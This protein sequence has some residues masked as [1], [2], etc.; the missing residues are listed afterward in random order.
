MRKTRPTC[1]FQTGVLASLR[2]RRKSERG[3]MTF[4]NSPF[5][6]VPRR[7]AFDRF[8]SLSIGIIR[9]LPRKD[10]PSLNAKQLIFK[11]QTSDVPVHLPPPQSAKIGKNSGKKTGKSGTAG[12]SGT[13]GVSPGLGING[14]KGTGV[15]AGTLF[16][17][18][19]GHAGGVDG[20]FFSLSAALLNFSRS[21]L[22]TGGG[23]L[24]LNGSGLPSGPYRPTFWPAGL[25]RSTWGPPWLSISG[26]YVS[27]ELP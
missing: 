8:I 12:N 16:W 19:A 18:G 9:N 17:F 5:L 21:L 3:G 23:V 27:L 1:D 13:T 24:P 4:G 11:F 25:Y 26:T 2:T 7:G 22:G 14:G 20:F 15:C 6:I 10:C